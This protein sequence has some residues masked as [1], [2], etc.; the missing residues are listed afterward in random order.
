MGQAEGELRGDTDAVLTTAISKLS[1]EEF[2]EV[3][4]N[5]EA[6]GMLKA[7]DYKNKTELINDLDNLPQ[8]YKDAVAE[9]L[10]NKRPAFE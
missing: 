3:L 5:A 10:K 2:L 8:D 1:E 6:Y 7:S 9:N 4:A